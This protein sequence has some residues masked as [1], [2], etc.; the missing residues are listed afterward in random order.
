MRAKR[1]SN[2]IFNQKYNLLKPFSIFHGFMFETK[3]CKIR[4]NTL[5]LEALFFDESFYSINIVNKDDFIPFEMS[6]HMVYCRG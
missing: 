2:F 5:V 4:Q 3:A 1:I 6:I